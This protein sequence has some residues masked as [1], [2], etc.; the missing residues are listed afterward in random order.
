MLNYLVFFI[1]FI[2]IEIPLIHIPTYF[3]WY[4][5]IELIIKKNSKKTQKEIC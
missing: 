1:F 2:L 4:L 5:P 3:Y